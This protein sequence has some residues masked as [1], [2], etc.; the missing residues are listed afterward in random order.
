MSESIPEQRISIPNVTNAVAQ[1]L[2][3]RYGFAILVSLAS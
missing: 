3:A 2:L 1:I